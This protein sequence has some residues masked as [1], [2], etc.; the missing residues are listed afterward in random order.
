MSS[1]LRR[2]QFSPSGGADVIKV[3]HPVRSD[4]QRGMLSVGGVQLDPVASLMI[5]HPN[6]GK[7]SIGIDLA[8]SEGR[9]LLYELPRNADVFMTNYLPSVR[10][11]LQIGVERIRGVN[12]DIIDAR[13]SGF[14]GKGPNRDRGGF[15]A[16]AF[17]IHSGVA[18]AL[19]PQ[20]FEVP[21][22]VGIGGMGDSQR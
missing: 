7:R 22:T 10:Q 11:N 19:T 21:L 14:G 12:P 20:D 9:D 4:P 16:I 18:H 5:E 6:R 13:G 1:S 8:T 17:W 2:A 15:D 3:E